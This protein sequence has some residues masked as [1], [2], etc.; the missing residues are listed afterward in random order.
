MRTLS[1]CVARRASGTVR[2]AGSGISVF[3]WCAPQFL[4]NLVSETSG[5]W[6]AENLNLTDGYGYSTVTSLYAELTRPNTGCSFKTATITIAAYRWLRF[7]NRNLSYRILIRPCVQDIK[8]PSK[9]PFISL[10]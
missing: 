8:S 6:P 2:T 7:S 5:L 9:P 10:P 1:T 3:G 4:G